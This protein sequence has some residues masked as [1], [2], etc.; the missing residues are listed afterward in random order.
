MN[1]LETR[2]F[3]AIGSVSLT[4]IGVT[5]ALAAVWLFLNREKPFPPARREDLDLLLSGWMRYNCLNIA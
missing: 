4:L 1:L 2:I 5:I 3:V